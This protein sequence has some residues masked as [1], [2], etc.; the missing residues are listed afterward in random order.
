M[1][2]EL[3]SPP[4]ARCSLLHSLPSALLP[5]IAAARPS[6]PWHK[7]H[8]LEPSKLLPW[9]RISHQRAPP[10]LHADAPCSSLPRKT[11]AATSSPSSM[12][13][14]L[15]RREWSSPYGQHPCFSLSQQ[16]SASQ[17][18]FPRSP[19]TSTRRRCS[20]ECPWEILCCAQQPRRLRALSARCFVKPSGQHAIDAHRLLLFLCS[21]IRDTVEPWW[22][23]RCPRYF[24]GIYDV[25]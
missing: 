5:W 6:S 10:L 24:S 9:H 22:E 3:F 13:S 11:A 21:P 14:S 18:S 7:L 2:L 16:R 25:R 4:G 23:P 12:V 20:T 19:T 17:P 8:F 15:P 1:V